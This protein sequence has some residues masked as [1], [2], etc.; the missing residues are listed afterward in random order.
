MRDV[1]AI[2]FAGMFCV[3]CKP[4][5][6]TQMQKLS[7]S[8]RQSVTPAELEGW[9]TKIISSTPRQQVFVPLVKDGAPD[10]IRKLINDSDS[11]EVGVDGLSND[12]VVVFTR[13]SG[14]GHWGFAVGTPKYA[15][16]LGR[17]QSHWTN[18][19]W[20]WHE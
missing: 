10:G 7:Q 2:I 19:I 4:A 9:A 14:F 15:C 8:V 1:I 13:G 17:V 20:F 6:E 5:V 16:S 11:L 3:G 18:G 12:V